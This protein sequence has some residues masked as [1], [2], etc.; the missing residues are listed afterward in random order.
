LRS[1]PVFLFSNPSPSAFSDDST[2][3]YKA[4]SFSSFLWEKINH[5]KKPRCRI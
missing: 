1:L 3:P 2:L 5:Q 4:I